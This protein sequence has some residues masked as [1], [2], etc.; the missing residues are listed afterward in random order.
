MIRLLLVRHA[1]PAATWSQSTDAPLDAVGVRQAAGVAARLSHRGPLPVTTSPLRRARETAAPLARRW[2][3]AAIVVPAVGEVPSPVD[4]LDARGSWLRGV[5]AARWTEVAPDL[6]RWRA[7]LLDRLAAFGS[8]AVVFTHYVAINTAV[9]AATGDDRLV[10]CMPGH[11]SVTE[12]DV[13]AAGALTPVSFDDPIAGPP[14]AGP[15]IDS[16]L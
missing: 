8:D 3:T 6:H 11:A 13:D 14:T 5:L 7:E 1:R 10:C 2:G 16:P 4:D 15:Q 9:G 12:L